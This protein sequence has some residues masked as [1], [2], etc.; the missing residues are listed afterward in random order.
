MT[1]N[2]TMSKEEFLE[3]CKYSGLKK[4]IKCDIITLESIYDKLCK[5]LLVEGNIN[6][7]NKLMSDFN[8]TLY[9]LK[10]VGRE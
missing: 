4:D 6:K 7:Y 1:V 8:D 2:V 10:E 3:Y 5:E 9:H